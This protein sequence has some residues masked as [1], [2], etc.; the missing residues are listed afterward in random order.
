MKILQI[1]PD[2][3]VGG[4]QSFTVSLCNELAKN[5]DVTLCV[6]FPVDENTFMLPRLSPSVKLISL[7]KKVGLDFGI[8]FKI[9]KIVQ[10]GDYDV[11]HTHLR[12]LFYT[13][14]TL[15]LLRPKLFH[16]VHNMAD[17]ETGK[18]QRKIY[19]LLFNYCSATP[20]GISAKVLK[21]VQAEYG[22]H[23]TQSIDNGIT[24]PKCS[25]DIDNVKNEVNSYKKDADTKIFVTIGRIEEQKNH[26][27]MVKVFNKLQEEGK[28]FTLLLIGEDP[29][30]EKPI[31][32][33]LKS[34]ASP[35]IHFLGAKNNVADYLSCADVFCLS[36]LYEGLPITLLEAM[37]MGVIPVCT[38]AGGIVDVIR[39]G[40][41]GFLSS[42]ISENSYYQC[43][44]EF[45]T[46]DA[47]RLRSISEETVREFDQHYNISTTAEKYVDLYRQS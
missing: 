45:F 46:L 27:M 34:I 14:L 30:P 3:Y 12:A 19:N 25:A 40:E 31:L 22:S 32:S 10:K 18:M 29:Y 47:T 15:I 2:L 28:N 20:V 42:D 43:L 39:H 6:L 17:K 4:A 37:A 33:Q 13:S 36:S 7:N 41:N 11:V 35:N 44:K 21:S 26:L 8:F 1:L 16:T 9:F 23:F 5:H 24:P 38:P